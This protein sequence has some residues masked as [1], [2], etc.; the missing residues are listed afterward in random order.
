MYMQNPK[1]QFH[2]NLSWI[3]RELKQIKLT[4]DLDKQQD[5]YRIIHE[6]CTKQ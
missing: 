6:E 2:T 3:M 1:E 4:L 5:E